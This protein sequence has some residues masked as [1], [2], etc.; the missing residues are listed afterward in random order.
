MVILPLP[1]PS[2]QGSTLFFNGIG[3]GLR[4][5]RLI[6]ME[7]FADNRQQRGY[8]RCPAALGFNWCYEMIV[9]Q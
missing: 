6:A 4:C 3:H 1:P 2:L 9:R 8:G 7:F 5:K